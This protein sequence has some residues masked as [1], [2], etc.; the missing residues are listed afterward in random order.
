LTFLK[1]TFRRLS[2]NLTA[3]VVTTNCNMFFQH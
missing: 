2:R 3:L 1:S